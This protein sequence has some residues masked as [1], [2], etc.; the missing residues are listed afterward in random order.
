MKP[1]KLHI[2]GN[3]QDGYLYSGQLFLIQNSG[4]LT[5]ISLDDIIA[6][7]LSYGTEEYNFFKLIF[8]RNDWFQNNQ[9]KTFFKINQF[10]SMFNL[11]WK[12]Y[13]KVEYT[14]ELPENIAEFHQKIDSTPI[15]DFKLYGMRVYIGNRDGLYEAPISIDKTV[16][17]NKPI[18][19][20]F[21]ARTTQISAKSG[22]VMISSNTEGLFHGKLLNYESDLNVAERP[23]SS[24]SLRTTWSGY[25]LVNYGTQKNFDYLLG[26][27]TRTDE[28]NYLYSKEDESSK[29]ITINSVG[30]KSI[31][32]ESLLSNLKFKEEDILYSFNSSLSCYF[33]LSNGDFL[34][35]YFQKNSKDKQVSLS[36]KI[37]SLP[38]NFIK[39]N[40]VMKP[41]STKIVPNGCIIEY[42]NQVVLVRNGIKVVLEDKPI[43]AIKTFPHSLRYKNIIAIFDGEGLSLHCMY[44]F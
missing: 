28:R 19:R 39:K 40:K 10:K 25:D 37:F 16:R 32:L 23:V 9:G 26:D 17:L 21:D 44:P 30:E 36:S 13:L 43:T 24:K 12:K 15:F 38:K 8:T 42:F 4:E 3:F 1:L 5:S 7:N 35:T 2:K 18:K 20:V 41:I 22:S 29:K 34:N 33:F 27:Y 14:F 31:S 6:A 11:M